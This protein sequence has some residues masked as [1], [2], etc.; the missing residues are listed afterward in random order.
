VSATTS[1]HVTRS[2]TWRPASAR[3]WPTPT[4]VSATSVS[5]ASTATPTVGR[6]SV[7]AELTTV[8]ARVNVCRAATSPAETTVKGRSMLPSMSV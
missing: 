5:V 8:T 6:A 1:G 2:V 7:T 3:V 4:V